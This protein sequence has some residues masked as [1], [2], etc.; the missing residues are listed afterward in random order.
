MS[1]EQNSQQNKSFLTAR[2]ISANLKPPNRDGIKKKPD[3]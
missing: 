2:D 1:D 3:I